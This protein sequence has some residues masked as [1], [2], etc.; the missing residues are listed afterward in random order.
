MEEEGAKEMAKSILE[1]ELVCLIFN[2]NLAGYYLA[3]YY[4][5]ILSIWYRYWYNSTKYELA[6]MLAAY[7]QQRLAID[8][9]NSDF[10][11]RWVYILKII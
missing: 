6:D 8:I 5:W 4:G 1:L 2:R 10:G 9:D 7:F 11:W 3:G